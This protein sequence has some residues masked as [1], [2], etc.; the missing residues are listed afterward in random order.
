MRNVKSQ[1]IV[2]PADIRNKQ[3]SEAV[4]LLSSW[5]MAIADAALAHGTD[6]TFVAEALN[7]VRREVENDITDLG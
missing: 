3:H 2:Y 1:V 4:S 5:F 6:P 7:D